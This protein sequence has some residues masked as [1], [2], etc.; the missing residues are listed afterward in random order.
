MRLKPGFLWPQWYHS[1]YRVST[2]KILWREKYVAN[3][4]CKAFCD[5]MI[6]A[7][8]N[9][10][11]IHQ[12]GCRTELYPSLCQAG[13]AAVAEPVLIE[14]LLDSIINHQSLKISGHFL[15]VFT[16]SCARYPYSNMNIQVGNITSKIA[17]HPAC[18]GGRIMVHW[19]WL[20]QVDRVM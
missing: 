9:F 10:H 13:W 6:R 11:P 5:F 3:L 15:E 17:A 12:L 20:L 14:W 18:V 4:P 8:R 16:L 2:C 7:A 19:Q 1:R